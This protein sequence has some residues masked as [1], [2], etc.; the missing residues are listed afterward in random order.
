MSMP[1]IDP[2]TFFGYTDSLQPYLDGVMSRGTEKVGEEECDVIELSLMKHQR[3]WYFWISSKDH[4][5]PQSRY[6]FPEG[7][8]VSRRSLLSQWTC[9][10]EI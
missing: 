4:L 6:L 3:S 2:S 5:P 9:L 7:A 1:I 8:S 10:D